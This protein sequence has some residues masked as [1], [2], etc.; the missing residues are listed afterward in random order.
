MKKK[1]LLLLCIMMASTAFLAACSARNDKNANL[2]ANDLVGVIGKGYKEMKNAIGEMAED[3]NEMRSSSYSYTTV[4]SLIL[5][6]LSVI[7]PTNGLSA[8]PVQMTSL[9]DTVTSPEGTVYLLQWSPPVVTK[10]IY[11]NL[12]PFSRV[13]TRALDL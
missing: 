10:L 3:M 8:L 7:S 1:F 9:P 12:P 5:N 11:L 6:W 4:I 13:S 2:T